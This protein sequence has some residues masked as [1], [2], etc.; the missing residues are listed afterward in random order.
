MSTLK[1]AVLMLKIKKFVNNAVSL[2]EMRK[3]WLELKDEE[4]KCKAALANFGTL[5]LKHGATGFKEVA[6]RVVDDMDYTH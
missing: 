4:C 3:V 1:K 5:C 6:H 2:D